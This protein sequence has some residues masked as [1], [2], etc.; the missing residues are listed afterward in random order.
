MNNSC[1]TP[2]SMEM[3]ICLEMRPV[4]RL[5]SVKGQEN[6]PLGNIFF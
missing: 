2:S 3:S 5:G 4:K 1:L 6:V